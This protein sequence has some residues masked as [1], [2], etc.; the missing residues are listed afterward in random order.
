[1]DPKRIVHIADWYDD[2]DRKTRARYERARATWEALGQSDPLW[3]THLHR[4]GPGSRTAKDIGDPRRLPYLR[5]VLMLG[6]VFASERDILCL[7][8]ADGC[9]V[10]ETPAAIREAVESSQTCYSHRIDIAHPRRLT[11]AQLKGRP[12]P[13]RAAASIR[14]P[15]CR[16]LPAKVSQRR[17]GSSIVP[18][19]AWERGSVRSGTRRGIRCPWISS[20]RSTRRATRLAHSSCVGSTRSSTPTR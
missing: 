10:P 16:R 11:R 3:E 14:S 4:L 15:A 2:P 18:R 6:R 20:P 1:M 9:L 8:N 13:G 7:T 12:F 19:R 17:A 5:D